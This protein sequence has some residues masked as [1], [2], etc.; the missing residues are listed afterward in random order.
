MRIRELHLCVALF[1]CFGP[2]CTL[3][4]SA[5]ASSPPVAGRGGN[6]AESTRSDGGGGLS[7]AGG[8][9][10]GGLAAGGTAALDV[11]IR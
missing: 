10:S 5:R 8:V 11:L 4:R 6:G 7:G 2:G 3:S 9:S 1:S